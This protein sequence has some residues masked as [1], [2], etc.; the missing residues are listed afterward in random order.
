MIKRLRNWKIQ[1]SGICLIKRKALGEGCVQEI[2]C[3]PARDAVFHSEGLDGSLWNAK[4]Y[5]WWCRCSSGL[6]ADYLF[7]FDIIISKDFFAPK[8]L[9][10]GKIKNKNIQISFVQVFEVRNAL[11]Q[12]WAYSRQNPR[13]T[14]KRR[15]LRLE[16]NFAIGSLW[17]RASSKPFPLLYMF[18]VSTYKTNQSTFHSQILLSYIIK[19]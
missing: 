15:E 3:N 5:W 7:H 2:A 1:S 14:V 10:P 18:N 13:M 16:P 19:G 8:A 4:R 6:Q 12:R 11:S 17:L 9:G